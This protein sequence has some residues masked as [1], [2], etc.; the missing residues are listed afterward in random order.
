MGNHIKRSVSLTRRDFIKA[1]LMGSVTLAVPPLISTAI[2]S[3]GSVLVTPQL[4]R[5]AAARLKGHVQHT[6]L[7]HGGMLSKRFGASLFLKLENMQY[8]GAFKERGALNKMSA[9]TSRE[10]SRGVIAASSGNHAQAVAY[11]ATRLGIPSVIV[12]PKVTP[13]IKIRRTLKLRGEVIV[14]GAEFDDSL[15]FA[16]KK[17]KEDGLTFIHP[18]NDPLVIAGQGTVGLEIMQDLPEAEILLVPVGGG[19]LVA[20]C[21]TAAKALNPKLKVYGVEAKGYAAMH[22]MLHHQPVKTGGET[23]AEGI[24]VHSVGKLPYAIDQRLLEDVLVV[25]EEH[26]ARAIT[27]IW[28][29]HKLVAEGAGAVGVAALLQ[30]AA[31]FQGKKIVAVISGGNIDAR[32]FATLLQQDM[33]REGRLVQIRVVSHGQG[34]IYPEVARVLA[35]NGAKVV[36]LQYEPIFHAAS[37]MSTAYDLIV[38][39]RDHRHAEAVVKGLNSAGF[40][41]VRMQ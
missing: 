1:F 8:T 39:T 3:T 16:L 25:D 41:A 19:G 4:V 36:D 35:K 11:H 21:A 17:A 6:P 18:F 5:E 40:K 7:V 28:A 32:L 24:A 33:H 10:R 37:P 34:D 14:Q 13:Q 38:E 22:Q 31:K 23:L 27:L 29:E 12:M 9:L 20:G 15:A 30:N 26:I 2:A